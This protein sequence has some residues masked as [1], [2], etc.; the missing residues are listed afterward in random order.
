MKDSLPAPA[1]ALTAP[2][3][4]VAER[5]SVE[6]WKSVCA[7]WKRIRGSARRPAR[8]LRL[9]ETLSLGERRFVAVVEF[10]QARF[11]V[12]GTSG[13]LVL[14]ARLEDRGGNDRRGEDQRAVF[15]ANPS[16]E[17]EIAPEERL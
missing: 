1:G 16:A 6:P 12:G 7:V 4:A 2:T 9:A 13:S 8:H 15:C 14:L 10:E 5:F 3:R 11:L 17:A